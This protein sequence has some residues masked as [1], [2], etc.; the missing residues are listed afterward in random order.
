MI[1]E[2]VRI[3]FVFIIK[4]NV[5]RGRRGVILIHLGRGVNLIHLGGVILIL[6]GK[7]GGGWGGIFFIFLE[8]ASNCFKINFLPAS[9]P[10]IL[11][12]YRIK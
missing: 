3:F 10:Q 9:D 2:S 12:W 6:W 4:K 7:G 5:G 1:S 11:H 8:N